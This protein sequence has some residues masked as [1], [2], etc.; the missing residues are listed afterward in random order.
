[1]SKY[2]QL[3]GRW[4]EDIAERY[5]VQRGYSIVGRNIR[6][7]YGEL[8]IVCQLGGIWVFVEVKTRKNI[9]LGQPETG[10][11]P[12][13]SGHLLNAAQDYLDNHTEQTVDWRID[14]I[15]IV[16]APGGG[17]PEIVHFENAVL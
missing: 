17:D 5:L 13:K 6:T 4:G 2:R 7:A 10:I 9:L 15:S 3:F 12:K 11:T 1:M 8:D 14:V 16:G